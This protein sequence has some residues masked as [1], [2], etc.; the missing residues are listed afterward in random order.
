MFH[1]YDYFRFARDRK[2]YEGNR[3]TT[4]HDFYEVKLESGM[5]QFS[6]LV[7]V[8][9]FGTC[10]HPLTWSAISMDL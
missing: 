3:S 8:Q 10:K 2:K 5:S 6:C 9:L 7:K 4:L 1:D